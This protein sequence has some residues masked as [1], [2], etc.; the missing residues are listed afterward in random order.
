MRAASAMVVNIREERVL[1]AYA[2]A[3]GA[4]RYSQHLENI[5]GWNSL[6][7]KHCSFPRNLFAILSLCLETHTT[8]LLFF[9]FARLDFWYH[10]QVCSVSVRTTFSKLI[11]R[12]N[13]SYAAETESCIK[14]NIYAFA[15]R[16]NSSCVLIDKADISKAL[17]VIR[18]GSKPLERRRTLADSQSTYPISSRLRYCCF[19]RIS[20]SAVQTLM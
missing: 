4:S 7:S 2:H 20:R 12:S 8:P 14:H 19:L 15:G 17:R 5:I 1:T 6:I 3:L 18:W 9:V 10:H 13:G 16:T 11:S